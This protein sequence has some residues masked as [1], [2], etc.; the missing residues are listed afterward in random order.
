M[1]FHILSLQDSRVEI[2]LCANI[3]TLNNEKT[4]KDRELIFCSKVPKSK[5]F[6]T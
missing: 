2:D 3:L 1:F 6:E 4:A 5:F